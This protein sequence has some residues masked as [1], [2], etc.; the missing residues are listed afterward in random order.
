MI[1]VLLLIAFV[2]VVIVVL[3]VAVGWCVS[4][5]FRCARSCYRRPRRTSF[6]RW[7]TTCA[8]LLALWAA[9]E[10]L[11]DF[12]LNPHTHPLPFVLFG[13]S[14]GPALTLL[15]RRGCPKKRQEAA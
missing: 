1:V 4:L 15:E 13:L 14:L 8:Y 7:P 10:V 6:W 9:Q 3:L 2:T 11:T 5:L 12:G